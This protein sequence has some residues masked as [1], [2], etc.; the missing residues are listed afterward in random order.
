MAHIVVTKTGNVITIDR[1]RGGLASHTFVRLLLI[2]R[3]M[4]THPIKIA[5]IHGSYARTRSLHHAPSYICGDLKCGVDVKT[6]E[7]GEYLDATHQ[8]NK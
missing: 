7:W 3:R 8:S 1:K 4:E 2:A 6:F 5:G